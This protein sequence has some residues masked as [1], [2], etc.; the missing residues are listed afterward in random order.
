MTKEEIVLKNQ[1][2]VYFVLNKMCIFDL[3]EREDL[4]DL[5]M[6][7]LIKGLKTY[8]E[9]KGA[10]STYL[11]ICIRS[12]IQTYIRKKRCKTISLNEPL[13]EDVFLEDTISDGTCFEKDIERKLYLEDK[14]KV[15]S[16]REKDC[17]IRNY[18]LFGH[19][20]ET[21]EQLAKRFNVS[22]N[23]ISQIIKIAIN[24]LRVN[25]IREDLENDKKS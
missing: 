12:S 11:F 20:K 5:G 14:M 22:Q 19:K 18:G 1:N 4:F 2:L 9:T 13:Y 10:L 24:K 8:D 3:Q 7:G 16:D 23:M 6:I 25:V 21:Q 15:L 17:L